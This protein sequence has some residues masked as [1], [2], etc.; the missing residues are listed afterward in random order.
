M[1]SEEV[2]FKKI[3]EKKTFSFSSLAFVFQVQRWERGL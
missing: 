2:I 1:I 3:A